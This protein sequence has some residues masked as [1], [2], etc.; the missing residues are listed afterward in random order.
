MNVQNPIA[1]SDSA[2]ASVVDF[3]QHR[4]SILDT[5]S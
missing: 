5:L 2:E 4:V 1:G 3:V